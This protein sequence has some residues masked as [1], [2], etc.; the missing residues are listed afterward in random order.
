MR[1]R[2]ILLQEVKEVTI[3]ASTNKTSGF[4]LSQFIGTDKPSWLGDYNGDMLKIDTGMLDIK[5]TATQANSTATSTASAVAAA[6]QTANSALTKANTNET[7]IAQLNTYLTCKTLNMTPIEQNVVGHFVLTYSPFIKTIKGH[8]WIAESGLTNTTIVG[9]NTAFPLQSTPGNI[10][11][12]QVGN[13]STGPSLFIGNASI[14]G[15][16]SINNNALPLFAYYD[17]VNTILCGTYTT[18]I[19]SNLKAGV[20]FVTSN[21]VLNDQPV[22]YSR[23]FL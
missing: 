23:L 2:G 4:S 18:A 7:S 12:L 16:D 15:P 13:I 5:A 10:F 6:Q 17:G 3:M 9:N 19:I 11:N 1:I 8:C 20:F 22:N 14:S 21:T